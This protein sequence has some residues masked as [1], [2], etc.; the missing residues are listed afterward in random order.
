MPPRSV[1]TAQPTLP[2][3]EHAFINRSLFADHFLKV[4]LPERPEWNETEGLEAAFT[5]LQRLYQAVQFNKATNEAQTEADFIRPALDI[6]WG[7][8]AYQVQVSLPGG[9][10][11]RQPDY[12]LFRSGEDR[13]EAEARKGTLEYWRTAPALADAKGWHASLDR[14]RTS[15]ENPSGQ[16]TRYLWL[17]QVRWGILTNGRTWRLY[18]REKSRVGGVYYEVDLEQILA[19]G[20]PEAFKYFYLFFRR[21]AL[22]PDATGATFLEKVFQGSVEYAAQVGDRLKESVYDALRLLING[23]L[24]HAPN[25]LDRRDPDTLKQVHENSLIVLYRLL[26]LLYAE[27]RELLPRSRQPYAEYSLYRRQVRINGNLRSGQEPRKDTRG[28]WNDLTYLFELIDTGLPDG[29]IPAYNGG[30]FSPRSYP[31]VAHTHQ[32]GFRRW[33]IGDWWLAQVIDLL[34][35]QRVRWDTPGTEDIDYQ[36]LDVQHLGSIYEGLL[37]LQPEVAAEAMVEVPLKDSSVFKPRREVSAPRPVR[38]QPPRAV[39]AG[40]VYLAT[41]RGERKATGSFY[42]PRFIV[43]YIVENTVGP[44]AEEAA[45]QAEALRPEVDREIARLERLVRER[46]AAG[47]AHE[48]AKLAG[49]INEQKRRLLEPYLALRILDPAMGSGHFL[50]G[51]ADFLSLAMATDPSLLPPDEAGDEDPQAFYKRLAVERCLYGVD[52]NPL[53]VELAKLSLWLHTVSRQR[54]LSFLD[55]HLRTGNS[56]VGAR[57]REDLMQ[58]P[59]R[60][61]AAGK[62]VNA[63]SKQLILGFTQALTQTHLHSFLD[64]FRRIVEAPSGDAEAE[65]QKDAWYREMDRVRDRFRKVADCWLAPHFGTSVSPEHYEEAIHALRGTPEEWRA[66][67]E[68]E[69]FQ[70]AQEAAARHRPFHWELEFPDLFLDPQGRSLEEKAGFHAV[71]GNPPYVRQELLGALKPTFASAFPEVYHGMADLF[72]YFFAQGLR[73]LQQGRRMAY[74]SSNSWLQTGFA[75]PL[76]RHVRTAATVDVLIDLGNNRTFREA[77]DVCPSIFVIRSVRPEPEHRFAS[78]VFHRGEEPDLASATLATKTVSITQHDQP[79]AGWQLGEDSERRLWDRL[80]TEGRPFTEVVCGQIYRGIVTGCNEVFI[81][82]RDTRDQLVRDDP[83]ASTIIRPALRGQDLRPWYQEDEGRWL[84]FT[85]RGIDIETYPG[86]KAYLEQFRVRLEPRPEDWDEALNGPWPGRKPGPYKWYEVQDSID[87]WAAFDGSK[88]V[89]PDIGKIP[90]FS[91]DEGGHYLN[92]TAYFSPTADTFLLGYLQ[93]RVAWALVSKVC[94]HNKF[95]GGLWEYRLFS[96]FISRLPIPDAAPPDR[97]AIG[98]LAMQITERAR[99]RYDL[100]QR[101]RR[102]IQSDL[103]PTGE[104]LGE[105]LTSWWELAFPAFHAELQKR[106]KRPIPLAERDEWDTFLTDRRQQHERL[107]GEIVALETELNDRVYRLFDLTAEEIHIIEET[108]RYRYGEV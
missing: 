15:D 36:T 73:L 72:V 51:A 93:S 60:Y 8:G 61:N 3:L 43:N 33:E 7:R 45:R 107:T 57:L 84:V 40:E 74:V 10:T 14:Q 53:S 67:E 98:G 26:F 63:E 106:F 35:F 2:F 5:A 31:H 92:N 29:G 18:E 30:L 37:E 44:V 77:P 16:I 81:I 97:E 65:H 24:E 41:N 58:E 76:R 32:E 99:D 82:D 83:N 48:A 20:N 91:W 12:A 23:F 19:H 59:P 4:R 90:R 64:T 87:Y 49:P 25:A 38:G 22:V 94:L 85:R 88:V 96:Q 11:R 95:R 70:A 46:E 6:L 108:T 1:K 75:E 101:T 17:S 52:L 54:A 79:D 80:M 62:R 47:Q 71:I 105:R 89:W 27:D 56:L 55:H 100:H 39:E 104:S 66:L 13:D 9:D 86:V 28:L 103:C 78:A 21:E 34:A 68:R 42:T 69:W 50:V 102:R